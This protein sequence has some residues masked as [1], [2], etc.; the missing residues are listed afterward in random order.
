MSIEEALT[1]IISLGMVSSKEGLRE[2]E[3]LPHEMNRRER[4]EEQS[5][6][7]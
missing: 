7:G 3:K 5:K 4:Q 6:D 2:Y 1:Y